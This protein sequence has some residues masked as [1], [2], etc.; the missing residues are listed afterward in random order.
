MNTCGFGAPAQAN[1]GD[2][3]LGHRRGRM[4]ENRAVQPG[5]GDDN[6]PSLGPA[7]TVHCT[8]DGW[9]PFAALHAGSGP[10]G[11]LAPATLATLHQAT[12]PSVYAGGWSTRRR[13]WAGGLALTHSGSNTMNYSIAW[14]GASKASGCPHRNQ[15]RLRWSCARFR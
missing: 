4:G 2:Q 6:P 14:G 13:D 12:P 9:L 3:P 1:E 10:P 5:P 11:Y 7:G 15:Y 8:L